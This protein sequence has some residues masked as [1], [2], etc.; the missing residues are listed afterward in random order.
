MISSQKPWPLD[1]EAGHQ[2]RYRPGKIK[3][4]G[5]QARPSHYV[6]TLYILP[7]W[8]LIIVATCL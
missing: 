6:Y 1:H 3:Y 4:L 2:I 7:T 8:R 5:K